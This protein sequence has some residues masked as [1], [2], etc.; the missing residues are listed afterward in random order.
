MYHS[1]VTEIAE[2]YGMLEAVLINHF[3]YW[4]AKNEANDRNFHD[5]R[6]WTYN[7]TKAL[8]K[9]FPYVTQKQLE[10]AL[11]HLKDDGIIMTGNYNNSAYDHTLW[12]TFTDLGKSISSFGEIESPKRGNPSYIGDITDIKPNEKQERGG[13]PK[14]SPKFVPP[15]IE[16]VRAYCREKGYEIDEERFLDHYTA[17]GWRQSNGNKII[18]WEATLRNW[19]G[20]EKEYSQQR[21][22]KQ[23]PHKETIEERIARMEKE[24]TLGKI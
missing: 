22:Q 1:F 13:P 14:R 20:R 4:L 11:K 21:Q 24:G 2:E 10:K 23:P 15:T 7:T 18:D 12:Y 6:Y 8:A 19:A 3:S 5:G 17:N 9:L 16:E